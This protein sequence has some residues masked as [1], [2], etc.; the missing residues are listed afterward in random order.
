[1][2]EVTGGQAPQH[3]VNEFAATIAARRDGVVLI[4]GSEAIFTIEHLA[5]TEKGADRP[6]FTEHG[7]GSLEDRGYGLRG[8]WSRHR[9]ARA[10]RRAGP[11]LEGWFRAWYSSFR[12]SGQSHGGRG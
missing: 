9:R 11:V 8:I 10:R 1:V 12:S 2:F 7:D 3:L 6:D 4:F 5:K